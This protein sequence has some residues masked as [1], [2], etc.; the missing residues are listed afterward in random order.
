MMDA[1]NRCY[2]F[3]NV[4]VDVQ[5]LRVTV[6]TEIRPLEPKSFRLL[7]FLV[8]NPG[9]ALTKDEIMASVWPG[10]FVS[11]NSL[12]RAITQI[13]KALDDDPK[14]PRYIETVPTVGYRFVGEC[15]QE[16]A[17]VA[18]GASIG[19]RES[20]TADA[21]WRP[22]RLLGFGA[23][24]GLL[25]G[26]GFYFVVIEG[27]PAGPY[28]LHVVSVAKLTSY[29][30][31]EREPAVSPD[32]STVAFSWSGASGDN[33][34][35]Y[36]VK[37]G[38]QEP[39]RLTTNPA[40]DTFPAWSP[41]GSQIAF[42]RRKGVFA[43]IVVVPPLGGAERVLHRFS[44]IGADLDFS[45]H[46]VLNWSPNGKSI[47]Y[48]GQSGPG[49]KYRLFLLS[50][51]TGSVQ[52]MSTPDTNVV[53]DSSPSFSGDGKFL[54]FVRYLAPRNGQVMIQ[55][56][57]S[58][59]N[60]QGDPV[61]VNASGLD[62]RSPMWLVDGKQL[63]FGDASR[64]FQWDQKK[65]T[66]TI[67]AANGAL[68]GLALGPRTTGNARRLVV[69]VDKWDSDIW[70]IPL[71]AAGMKATEAP[72][73]L[74]RSTASDA[75]P[76]YSPD[77]RLVTFVSDRSGAGE[78]WVANADGSN[79]RQ[80]T[81]LG[82]HVAS[83]PKWSPDGTKIAFH[84]RVPDVAEVYVVDVNQGVPQQVTHENPGLALA[85]W[86]NDGRFLYA[87]TLLGGIGTTYRFP[88][89]GGAMERLC[90]G[91]LARESVDGKY[92]LYWKT[93]TPGIFR[94]SLA[95][96]VAKNPEELLVPDFWPL[97]QLGGYAPVAG[98]I[99]YVSPNAEGK[100]GSFRYFDY[101]SR[102]STEIAPAVPGL[103]RGFAISPDRRH[104]AFSASAEIGGDLL[105]LG[106]Q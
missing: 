6:G 30:G 12:A 18:G 52:V 55:A 91:A 77:G 24:L 58:G 8:E 47:V 73:I 53:G 71:N 2:R 45:Q 72:Q 67:Y 49:E 95:G 19:R 21:R 32:G 79:P 10:A 4:Q 25:A 103:G 15:R 70:E 59:M 60:L 76:D 14:T 33:Y 7:V 64:I 16:Q 5:N 84:A 44:R 57:D 54:A 89:T 85:T 40:A 105:L 61:A 80:L 65:G 38:G 23:G 104:M 97:G 87:S 51:E 17:A 26:L 106:L 37:P 93:N 68:G 99:Y 100:P 13:R 39:L 42:V 81:H 34:D 78:V 86:S 41:D 29:P 75:H 63:L 36:V 20:S 43:E 48:S 56:L 69:A 46:P 27:H 1:G 11:D 62:P 74:Q 88:A 83:Y 101:A 35:I 28:P 31:D 9:R 50:V 92:I 3:D 94:R 66:T 90:E 96:D 22:W 98:G 102:K 82:A